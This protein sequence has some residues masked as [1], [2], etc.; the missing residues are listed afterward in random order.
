[1][2]ELIKA[3]VIIVLIVLVVCAIVLGGV[4]ATQ[5]VVEEIRKAR[6]FKGKS[7]NQRVELSLSEDEELISYS[8]HLTDL[9]SPVRFANFV[10]DDRVVKQMNAFEHGDQAYVHGI[11][12]RPGPVVLTAMREGRLRA[13]IHFDDAPT[14]S[15]K[16]I[17]K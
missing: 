5:V 1:M 7:S 3:T 11:W 2:R 6:R 10:I 12:K 14:R 8:F 4:K 16:L 13:D 15:I 17:A 9:K